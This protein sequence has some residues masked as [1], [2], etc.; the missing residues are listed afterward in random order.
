ML[1]FLFEEAIR[2]T[3]LASLYLGEVVFLGGFGGVAGLVPSNGKFDVTLRL[4]KGKPATFVLM[5]RRFWWFHVV[6]F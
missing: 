3:G 4:V 6:F 5:G 1:F 2:N